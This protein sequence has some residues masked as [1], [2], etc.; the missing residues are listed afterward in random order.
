MEIKLRSLRLE[1]FKG[2]RDFSITPNGRN[3]SIRG[4]NGAGKTT[5]FDG[6]DW[7]FFD[8]NSEGEADFGIKT[9][10]GRA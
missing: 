5:I 10:L 6:F 4:Q 9:H 7:L 3:C 1:N 2:V 8:K